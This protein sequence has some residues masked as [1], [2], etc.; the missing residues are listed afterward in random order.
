MVQPGATGAGLHLAPIVH[1]CCEMDSYNQNTPWA[2]YENGDIWHQPV[3]IQY[4]SI[5]DPNTNEPYEDIAHLYGDII[6]PHLAV[7]SAATVGDTWNWWGTT[8][9]IL[10]PTIEGRIMFGPEESFSTTIGPIRGIVPAWSVIPLGAES[11]TVR[12][13]ILHT[14]DDVLALDSCICSLGEYGDHVPRDPETMEPQ[15]DSE[16]D[17]SFGQEHCV[18]GQ[19]PTD[20]QRYAAFWYQ[21]PCLH[22]SDE[23][24]DL[25]AYCKQ[26]T[27][28]GWMALY[29]S[30]A[31]TTNDL[32]SECF[33]SYWHSW[34]PYAGF[35][36]LNSLPRRL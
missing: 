13:R 24:K 25:T 21:Q 2:V 7:L 8:V 29:D 31:N 18:C 28:G 33:S 19:E 22:G 17:Y 14:P 30:V 5:M 27:F 10:R 26:Q 34:S 6:G 9:G 36:G 4:A 12:R 11:E 35:P 15:Y 3:H 1:T 16:C 23:L 20:E 32:E